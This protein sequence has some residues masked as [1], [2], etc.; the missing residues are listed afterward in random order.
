MQ[1]HTG[2]Q[3]INGIKIKLIFLFVL[4]F[5]AFAPAGAPA[6]SVFGRRAEGL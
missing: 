4:V 1:I 2:M 3:G 6:L 5:S